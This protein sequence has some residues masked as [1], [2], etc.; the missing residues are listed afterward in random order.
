MFAEIAEEPTTTTTNNSNK[1]KSSSKTTRKVKQQQPIT[2]TRLKE[3][4]LQTAKRVLTDGIACTLQPNEVCELT[5]HAMERVASDM[6][7]LTTAVAT[8]LNYA[9]TNYDD[10]N[11]DDDDAVVVGLVVDKGILKRWCEF[12]VLELLPRTKGMIES[13]TPI[14]DAYGLL[15]PS[16]SMGNCAVS[17]DL[18]QM[19]M[20]YEPPETT[21]GGRTQEGLD[22]DDRVVGDDASDDDDDANNE[23][24][25]ECVV[26]AGDTPVQDGGGGTTLVGENDAED[27]QARENMDEGVSDYEYEYEYESEQYSDTENESIQ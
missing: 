16:N 20:E 24:T 13:T 3:E 22:E 11:D 1:H 19:G 7:G 14:L 21:L 10:D 2:S 27:N 17:D 5:A 25:G 4:H 26:V 15:L 9:L 23:T 12:Y 8:A 6:I 18:L